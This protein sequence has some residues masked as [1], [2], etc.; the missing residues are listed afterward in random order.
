MS[1]TIPTPNIQIEIISAPALKDLTI[2]PVGQNMFS[3]SLN[4]ITVVRFPSNTQTD[5]V[6]VEGNTLSSEQL[7][8]ADATS[9]EP[10]GET[11][12]FNDFSQQHGYFPQSRT[13]LAEWV[14]LQK[15][16]A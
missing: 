8:Y 15:G 11:A 12:A 14:Q 2:T 7:R 1:S 10:G 5:Q 3:L 6:S 9:P 4:I 13:V 16:G